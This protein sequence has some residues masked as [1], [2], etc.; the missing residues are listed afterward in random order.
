[1]KIDD[2]YS[3]DVT[4]ATRNEFVNFAKWFNEIIGHEPLIVGE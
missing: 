1:M 2:F 3:D 4:R